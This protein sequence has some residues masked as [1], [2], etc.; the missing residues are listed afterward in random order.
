MISSPESA[1]LR[2]AATARLVL[3]CLLLCAP[4][5]CSDADEAE[6]LE[7]HLV[8][9]ETGRATFGVDADTLRELHHSQLT[10]ATLSSAEVAARNAGFDPFCSRFFATADITVVMFRTWCMPRGVFGT[11]NTMAVSLY[12]R[13]DQILMGPVAEWRPFVLDVQP[14]WQLPIDSIRATALETRLRGV[15]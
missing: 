3:V 10:T 14:Q 8:L 6:T 15:E 13:D 4:I 7:G 9:T 2:A 5:G 1:G 12:D 11:D